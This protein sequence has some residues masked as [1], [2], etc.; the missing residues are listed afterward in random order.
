MS[1]RKIR[2]GVYEV[3]VYQ[4]VDKPGARPKPMVRH[5]QGYEAAQRVQGELQDLRSRGGKID[6]KTT[7]ADYAETWLEGKGSEDLARQT[8]ANYRAALDR[9]VL[10]GLGD[11]RL[12]A[13]TADHIRKNNAALKKRGLSGTTRLTAYRALRV[14]LNT[15]HADGLIRHNPIASVKAPADDTEEK[16]ALTQE[17]VSEFL[18]LVDGTR[19]QVAAVV[20]FAAGLR[21]QELLALKWESVDLK[22]G[23]ID[24]CAAVEQVNGEVAIKPPKSKRSTRVVPI[25]ADTIA[26]LKA[27]RAAQLAYRAKFANKWH[28]E[29]LVF[30]STTVTDAE[31]VM[32]RIWS[33]GAFSHAWAKVTH[34]TK[35][36]RVTPHLCRHTYI[37]TL[38]V[39]GHR[40][41]LVSRQA[42]H[43]G[44][45]VTL[46]K[47]SHLLDDER[48]VI[49]LPAKARRTK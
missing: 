30:P 14:M 22:A 11:V 47:Y 46:R 8:L 34:G 16:D 2:E 35:Y 42:G 15:A 20:M 36:E 5:V 18:A 32:G 26:A 13:L 9:Y 23:T 44:S 19:V 6:S 45:S 29:G 7:V 43:S 12:M 17:Q 40:L 49:E 31:H 48:A 37:T 4:R 24:V 27:H 33:P 1:I 38:F 28:D 10:P 21:R 39:N 41:E 3:K 25:G